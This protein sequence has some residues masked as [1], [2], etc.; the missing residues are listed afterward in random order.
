MKKETFHRVR[1]S[2]FS[3]WE[4]GWGR[5]AQLRRDTQA[6]SLTLSQRERETE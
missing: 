5:G 6:L 2:P 3:L 1:K 4:K